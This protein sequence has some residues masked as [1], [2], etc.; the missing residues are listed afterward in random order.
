MNEP[1]DKEEILKLRSL[2]Y[3]C[4]LWRGLHKVRSAESIYQVDSVQEALPGLAEVVCN[5]VGYY[6][7]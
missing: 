6:K 4:E 7:D 5:I 2:W 3:A 1:P